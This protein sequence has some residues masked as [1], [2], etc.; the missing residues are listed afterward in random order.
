MLNFDLKALSYDY[1]SSIYAATFND[2]AEMSQY[3]LNL[4]TIMYLCTNYSELN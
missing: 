4:G 3:T 2:K 1:V